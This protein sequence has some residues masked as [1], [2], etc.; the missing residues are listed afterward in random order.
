MLLTDLNP[1]WCSHGGEGSF[2]RGPNDEEV[3]IP[4]RKRI[5]LMYDCPCGCGDRR[6]VPFENPE[7]GK[8]PLEGKNHKWHR[9]GTT[10]K[11]LTLSPSIRHIPL[12]HG[13]CSWHGWIRDGKVT[14]A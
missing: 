12:E 5:G 13:D 2:R 9:T 1:A 3:P 11:T 14:N 8:G 10:F 4:E 7:D 6:Y